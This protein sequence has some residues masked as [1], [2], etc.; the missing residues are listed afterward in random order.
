M[1]YLARLLQ[2][3]HSLR[4][5]EK[6]KIGI[7]SRP[8]GQALSKA[9]VVE[10]VSFLLYSVPF[11]VS[12]LY[13][14]YLWL[15]KGLALS[16]PS[17]VYL[18]VTKDPL[19]FL[20]GFLAICVAVTVEVWMSASEAR[21]AKVMENAKRMRWLALLCIALSLLSAW[22]ATGYSLNLLNFLG[23]YLEGRYAILFPALLIGVSFLIQPSFR[24]PVRG[25]TLFFEAIPLGLTILSPLLL[26]YLSRLNFSSNVT[27]GT[28]LLTFIIGITL[29]FYGFRRRG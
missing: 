14:L 2:H 6:V 29:L 27:F 22:S 18:M 1:S 21:G 3:R 17:D 12:G 26:F 20:L 7:S 19:V 24:F 8:L 15:P 11:V 25:P 10:D 9:D 5:G 4:L 23:L 28:P 16:L 13:A